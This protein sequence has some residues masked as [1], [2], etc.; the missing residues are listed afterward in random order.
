MLHLSTRL[1]A[2]A[3]LAST[4]AAVNAGAF[5]AGKAP[6]SSKESMTGRMAA[7]TEGIMKCCVQPAAGPQT[8][9][10]ATA[11]SGAKSAA[12]KSAK[13]GSTKM[14][15]PC[16]SPEAEKQE[17]A[18]NAAHLHAAPKAPAPAAASTASPKTAAQ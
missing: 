3:V 9:K 11:K 4:L 10:G 14:S 6:S 13:A 8:G 17:Q 18:A 7:H 1:F 15:C 2:T 16:C 5:A 12:A